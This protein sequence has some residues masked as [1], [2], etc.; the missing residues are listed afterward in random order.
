MS[1]TVYGVCQ[2]CGQIIE[3]RVTTL[4]SSADD[5]YSYVKSQQVHSNCTP[6]RKPNQKPKVYKEKF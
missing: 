4:D 3:K 6:Q 2:R 5:T 1:H